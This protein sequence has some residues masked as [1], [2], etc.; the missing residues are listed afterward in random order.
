MTE[1]FASALAVIVPLG[2]LEK[3]LFLGAT[4]DTG[5]PPATLTACYGVPTAV[6]YEIQPHNTEG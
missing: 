1:R 2:F 3:R 4:Q 6:I 5:I